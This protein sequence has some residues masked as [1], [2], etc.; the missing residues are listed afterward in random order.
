MKTTRVALCTSSIDEL[1]T[2]AASSTRRLTK[3]PRG[4]RR[5]LHDVGRRDQVLQGDRGG[6]RALLPRV[7]VDLGV[8]DLRRRVRVEVV[9]RYEH[10]VAA[11]SE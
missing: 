3:Q 2:K 6:L 4:A 5:E 11:L 10:P 7:V 1:C 9:R 8:E